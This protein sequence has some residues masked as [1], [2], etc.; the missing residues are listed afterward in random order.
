[1]QGADLE[2][3]LVLQDNLIR[4]LRGIVGRLASLVEEAPDI[5]GELWALSTDIANLIPLAEVL[6]D[7][8]RFPPTPRPAV[9][10]RRGT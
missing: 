8:E 3:N 4:T 9:T 6:R 2:P 10:K 7:R 1:M 5:D